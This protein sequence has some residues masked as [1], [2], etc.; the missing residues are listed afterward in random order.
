MYSNLK[1]IVLGIVLVNS[2]LLAFIPTIGAS[3][4][5]WVMM[6]D[7]TSGKAG[8]TGHVIYVNGTWNKTIANYYITMRYDATKIEITGLSLD[9][10]PAAAQNWTLSSSFYQDDGTYFIANVFPNNLLYI[11]AGS[12][13]LL[14]ITVNIKTSASPGATNLDLDQNVGPLHLACL[15]HDTNNLFHY[16]VLIDGTFIIIESQENTPPNTPSSPSPANHATGIAITQSLSWT[17][18]DPNGDSVTYKVYFGTTSN[19]PLVTT[20]TAASYNPGA[21]NYLTTYYWKIIATDSNGASTTGPLWQFTTK[22]NIT[23]SEPQLSISAPSSISEETSF[24]VT[25][26]ADGTSVADVRVGFLDATYLSDSNGVVFFMAPQVEEDT[27]YQITATKDGYTSSSIWITVLNSEESLSGWVQGTVSETSGN[28]TLPLADT[29]V[30][31]FLTYE[32]SVITSKCTFTDKEGAYAIPTPIG[33]YTLKA[34]KKGYITA[35]VT[36]VTI[37]GNK[38]TWMNFTL[39]SGTN[40]EPG[41]FP[42]IVKAYRDEIDQAIENGNVGAELLVQKTEDNT[43]N[44]TSITYDSVNITLTNITSNEISLVVTGDEY[45]FGK[46]IVVSVEEFQ[47]NEEAIVLYDGQAINMADDI[48]D[49]LNPNDDGFHAE[50]LVTQGATGLEVLVSIPHFSEHSISIYSF[51]KVGTIIDATAVVLY[52]VIAVIIAMVFVGTGE[53]FKR[54]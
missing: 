23:P 45:S 28:T 25:I 16:P 5:E 36:D 50:Y 4:D 14:K 38:I 42:V 44:S 22:Q 7:N 53:L 35:T 37:T 21:L 32:S 47:L 19:P 10:G 8:D 31:L 54:L 43:Y 17:G 13:V 26:T 3:E 33:T 15:F 20:T 39:E 46:T 2:I 48:V 29:M 9:G 6:V 34:G 24:Q 52:I 18:G 12:G 1:A 30:C 41:I 11:A 51:A 40:S 27:S 49:V